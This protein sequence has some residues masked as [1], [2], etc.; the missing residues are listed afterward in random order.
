[1]AKKTENK[2]YIPAVGKRKSAVARVRILKQ[3]AKG[4]NIVINGKDFKEY[5]AYK[6]WQDLVIKPLKAVGQNDISL[7]IKAQGGGLRGQIDA[8]VNGIA[9]ALL[10]GDE[11]LRTTLRKEGFLTRDSRVK[12]RKKPGLRKARRAPQ[13]SKR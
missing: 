4:I 10:K 2:D 1:M 7:S 9:K 5:F 13:W 11:E 12:E 6:D 3:S 8:I